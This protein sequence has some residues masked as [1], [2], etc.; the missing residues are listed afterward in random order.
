MSAPAVT[1]IDDYIGLVDVNAFYV[2]AERVFDPSL[3][4]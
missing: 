4:D 2:S 1:H 3:V